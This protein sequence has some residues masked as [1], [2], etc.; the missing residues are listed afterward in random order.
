MTWLPVDL[1]RCAAALVVG[2]F[3]YQTMT[4]RVQ[5]RPLSAPCRF[6]RDRGEIFALVSRGDG[7][8]H[9][10]DDRRPPSLGM[11][12]SIC[13]CH[14][15]VNDMYS[16]ISVRRWCWSRSRSPRRV[17]VIGVTALAALAPALG[18]RRV[19]RSDEPGSLETRAGAAQAVR[20]DGL[21]ALDMGAVVSRARRHRRRL[22]ISGMWARA[23]TPA[24][25][26]GHMSRCTVLPAL[27]SACSAGC[28]ARSWTRYMY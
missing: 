9:R 12:H 11:A 14:A 13:D 19:A 25:D 23:R 18:H 1:A 8:R 20:V 4:F 22:R 6:R 24:A 27:R 17:R 28:N 15:N 7:H 26:L 2:C 10:G 5:R 16:R 21:A 3:D